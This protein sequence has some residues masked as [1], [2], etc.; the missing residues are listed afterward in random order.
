M[1]EKLTHA[2]HDARAALMGRY[3]DWRDGTYCDPAMGADDYM[4]DAFTLKPRRV[5]LD[6]ISGKN[7]GQRPRPETRWAFAEETDTYLER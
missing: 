2:E 1:A 6:Q 5:Q 4:L 3:Y 7:Y